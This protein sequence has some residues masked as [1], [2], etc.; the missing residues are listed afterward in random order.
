MHFKSSQNIITV[1]LLWLTVMFLLFT[2]FLPTDEN[3]T[4]FILITVILYLLAGML[5]WILVDTKYLIRKNELHYFSGP[6]R[7]KIDINS[8]Y[9][10]ENI[11]TWFVSSSLKPALG[12]KG[13]I[14]HYNKFDDIYISPK[15]KEKFIVELLKINP[16]IKIV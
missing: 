15:E 9:K 13:F 1:S 4:V 10:I 11:T 16:E 14:I 5:I 7:G 2:P 3:A 6:I 12:F 8:I